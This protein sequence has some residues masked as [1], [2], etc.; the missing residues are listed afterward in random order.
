MLPLPWH[1]GHRTW[2][3]LGT[4]NEWPAPPDERFDGAGLA[5]RFQGVAGVAEVAGL[6]GGANAS[7]IFASLAASCL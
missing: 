4:F 3:M 1:V 7:W 6:A 5:R 2:I